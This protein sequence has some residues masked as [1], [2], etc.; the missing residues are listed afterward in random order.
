MEV[1]ERHEVRGIT[2]GSRSHDS[3]RRIL[4]TFIDQAFRIAPIKEEEKDKHESESESQHLVDEHFFVI[5][6]HEDQRHESSLD[7]G[8]DHADDDVQAVCGQLNIGQP[9]GKAR[10]DGEEHTDP[11]DLLDGLMDFFRAFGHNKGMF[12]VGLQEIKKWEQED[13]D[14]IHKVPEEAAN[15]DAVGHVFWVLTEATSINEQEV[16]QNQRASDDV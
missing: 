10:K 8:K 4:E 16:G 9:H 11:E 15:F 1:F 12:E 5:Q 3:S 7:G 14:K 13:P 6:V 2:D